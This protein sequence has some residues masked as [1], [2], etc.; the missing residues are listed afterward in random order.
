[1]WTKGDSGHSQRAASK[2]FKVPTALVS[3]SSNAVADVQF[4]MLITPQGF[5]ES[6]LIPAGVA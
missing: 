4:V 2:R 6:A 5:F 1:M 3:K